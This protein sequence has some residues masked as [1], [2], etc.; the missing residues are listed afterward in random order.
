MTNTVLSS[1]FFLTLLLMVGLF[2]FVRAATK[3]RT[4]TLEATIGQPPESVQTIL[5]RYFEQRAYQVAK[6]DA[7]THQVT[8]IGW[9]RPSLFLA[10]FLSLMTAVGAGCL[11]LVLGILFPDYAPEFLGLLALAP[12]AGLF[13]WRRAGRTEQVLMTVEPEGTAS[14]A[15]SKMTVIAHRD[16]L[17]SLKQA[18]SL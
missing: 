11:A 4:E 8:F 1:T 15:S 3:D 18:L 6:V 12:A 16:E 17:L 9:V 7:A 2:F 14:S 5:Q 13:Y 10:T